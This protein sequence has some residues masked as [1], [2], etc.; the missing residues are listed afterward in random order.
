MALSVLRSSIVPLGLAEVTIGGAPPAQK[1]LPFTMQHQS[2]TNWCWAA[3]T[4]SIATFLKNQGWTQCRVVNE[5]L[6][7]SSCC[8]NGD[9]SQCNVPYFLDK[10]LTHVGNLASYVANPLP[11]ARVESE[12]D[13]GRPIGVRIGWSSGGGHFVAVTGYSGTSIVDV[14]DPWFGPSTHDYTEFCQRYLGGG[15][16]THSYSTQPRGV[17]HAI[18]TSGSTPQ[19]VC[20]CYGSH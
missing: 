1:A 10:A 12:I 8:G 4:A 15:R 6:G 14:Q 13:G 19:R 18:A 11:I 16:W 20:S 17:Q 3:V 5:D 7:Q 9:S 2:Q